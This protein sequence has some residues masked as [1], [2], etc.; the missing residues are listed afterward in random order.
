[1][2]TRNCFCIASSFLFL[3]FFG[4]QLAGLSW[5]GF[6][7]WVYQPPWAIY[8]PP[9]GHLPTLVGRKTEKLDFWCSIWQFR[10]LW[11]DRMERKHIADRNRPR[12]SNI[13]SYR[14][15]V[16]IKIDDFR[17]SWIF[18]GGHGAPWG[19]HVDPMGSPWGPMGPMGTH[20]FPWSCR[21]QKFLR[22]GKPLNPKGVKQIVRS[23]SRWF[24]NKTM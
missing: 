12:A 9:V 13:L 3:S 11:R 23:S 18:H 19:P 1:M 8:Q 5:L 6:W 24:R 21:D 2:K 15:V 14:I 10:P 16:F 20:G 7:Y 22:N 4:P 17:H